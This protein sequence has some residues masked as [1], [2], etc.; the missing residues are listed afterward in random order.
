LPINGALPAPT[1]NSCSIFRRSSLIVIAVSHP[2]RLARA[3]PLFEA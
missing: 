1:P 2:L 3:M